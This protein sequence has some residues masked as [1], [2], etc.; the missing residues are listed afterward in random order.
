MRSAF[1]YAYGRFR[2]VV[3]RLGAVFL[4]L[5]P[6][7]LSHRHGDYQDR[8]RQDPEEL[9]SVSTGIVRLQSLHVSP[10]EETQGR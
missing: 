1:G 2:C 3:E 6:T 8:M 10:P 5:P 9:D 4:K 7:H